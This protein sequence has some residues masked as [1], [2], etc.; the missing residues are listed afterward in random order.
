MYGS[1]GQRE[2]MFFFSKLSVV[3]KSWFGSRIS[4]DTLTESKELANFASGN[5]FRRNSVLMRSPMCLYISISV[6]SE[7]SRICGFGSVNNFVTN[8]IILFICIELAPNLQ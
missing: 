5:C 1:F 6:S 3:M 2:K 8:D 4:V 7:R